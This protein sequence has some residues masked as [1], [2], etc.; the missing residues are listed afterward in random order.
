VP[1]L[2]STPGKRN[3]KSSL[4]LATPI[5]EDLGLSTRTKNA[6]INDQVRTVQDLASKSKRELLLIPNFGKICLA[7]VQAML[8]KRG[9]HLA[10]PTE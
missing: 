4:D 2:G 6:L 7:E 9:L 5:I 8:A 1:A 3:G 10:A